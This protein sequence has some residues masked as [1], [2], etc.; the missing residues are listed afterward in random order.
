MVA[1]ALAEHI[2]AHMDQDAVKPGS[3]SLWLPQAILLLPSSADSGLYRVQSFFPVFQ[4]AVGQP[5]KTCL[6]GD[7][8]AC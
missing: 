3:H 7:E 4:V 6:F 5:V 8:V 1:I 2:G